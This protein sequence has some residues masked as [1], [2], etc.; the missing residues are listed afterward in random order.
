MINC[1]NCSISWDTNWTLNAVMVKKS[2]MMNKKY[3]LG[4]GPH[5]S[6]ATI[7]LDQFKKQVCV[8]ARYI[9]M[10]LIDALC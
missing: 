1:W 7:G 2:T 4:E 5:K 8:C 9:L 3:N 10:K 6:I